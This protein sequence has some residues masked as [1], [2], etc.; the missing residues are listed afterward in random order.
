MLVAAGSTSCVWI[1]GERAGRADVIETLLH[2]YVSPGVVWSGAGQGHANGWG[3]EISAGYVTLATRAELPFFIGGFYRGQHYDSDFG[4]FGRRCYGLEAGFTFFG[5]EFGGA[6]R[7]GFGSFGAAD[8]IHLSPFA[9]L[10]FLYVGPQWLFPSSGAAAE[11]QFNVGLKLPIPQFLLPFALASF[12]NLGSLGSVGGRALRVDGRPRVA[13]LRRTDAW[14]ARP[15]RSRAG[16]PDEVRKAVAAHWTREALG[17]HA[18]IAAFARLA[19]D[20][21]AAGAPL[22]LVRRAHE[23]AVD[24]VGHARACFAVAG[25]LRGA[26]AGP[27]GLRT[28]R[29]V[30]T[31]SLARLARE[32]LLDGC[33][34]EGIAAGL[35]S[36]LASRA[37][38]LRLRRTL[39]RIARDESRHAMLAWDIVDALVE[40]GGARVK[41][42][43]KRALDAL[44]LPAATPRT[45]P[46]ELA[47]FGVA[48]DAERAAIASEVIRRARTRL[49]PL[50]LARRAG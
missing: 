6:T 31:V 18:S 27:G 24:E 23:A 34:G 33:I 8:G 47:R 15:V 42:A 28:S 48:S 1:A 36:L 39:L 19:I 26:E 10:G 3:G 40:R 45:A 29:A 14:R 25:D 50:C 9:T 7:D 35:A 37:T 49:D 41:A 32:S 21:L 11:F 30:R 22:A 16:P 38:D 17:E 44:S 46:G 5:V 2:V 20:S 13:R 4:G 43:V 12:G